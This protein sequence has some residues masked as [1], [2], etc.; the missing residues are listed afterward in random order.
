MHV[1]PSR[2]WTLPLLL[3]LAFTPL[4]VSAH[5]ATIHVAASNSSQSVKSAAD[6]GC[7]GEGDQEES[8]AAVKTLPPAGGTVELSEGRF[9]IRRVPDTLVSG[10]LN[11]L[12]IS[13]QTESLI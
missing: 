10:I 11:S 9:D 2:I 6:F 1:A 5:A 4:L 7:D 8:S 12:R 3:G 13:G